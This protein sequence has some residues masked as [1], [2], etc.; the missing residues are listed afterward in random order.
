MFSYYFILCDMGH[1]FIFYLYIYIYINRR[2]D[3]F[4]LGK[5]GDCGEFLFFSLFCY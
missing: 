1:F 5:G 3:G 2:W 4:F